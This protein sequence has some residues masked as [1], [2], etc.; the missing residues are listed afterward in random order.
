MDWGGLNMYIHI[1]VKKNLFQ[2]Y[3]W[4]IGPSHR[5]VAMPSVVILLHRNRDR[6]RYRD[7]MVF[8]WAKQTFVVQA[9]A[10]GTILLFFDFF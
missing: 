6:Y 10:R 5:S 1:D 7:H 3:T 2:Q 4:S 8:R 9:V